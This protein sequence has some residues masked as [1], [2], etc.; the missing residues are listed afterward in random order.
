[1]IVGDGE[2]HHVRRVESR[3]GGSISTEHWLPKL[4]IGLSAMG[5]KKL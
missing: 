1:M 3:N 2:T 5:C 4:A